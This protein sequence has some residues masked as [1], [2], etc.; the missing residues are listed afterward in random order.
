M[1]PNTAAAA[2]IT[3]MR[4]DASLPPE[5]NRSGISRRLFMA[6]LTGSL[7]AA[8]TGGGAAVTTF[9]LTAPRTAARFGGAARGQV[10][11]SDPTAIQTLEGERILVR[12]ASGTVTFLGGGQWADRLPKLVQARLINTFENASRLQ[13]VSRPGERVTPDYVLSTEIRSFQVLTPAGEALV[14]ISARLVNDRSGRIASSRV[15]SSRVPVA[16][17][18]AAAAAQALDQALASVLVDIVRWV[19]SGR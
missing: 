15:F 19:S 3:A 18:N 6:T 16:S 1:S 4:P 8:C 11:V 2:E 13:A 7:A 14:E 12:D 10:V 5:M 17:V 9:D